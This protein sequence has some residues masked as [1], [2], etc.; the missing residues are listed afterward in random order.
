M[1]IK[2]LP[3]E[4]EDFKDNSRLAEVKAGVRTIELDNTKVSFSEQEK[5]GEKETAYSQDHKEVG[6]PIVDTVYSTESREIGKQKGDNQ[7]IQE[8]G[9]ECGGFSSRNKKTVLI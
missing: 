6:K 9:D 7:L 2:K 8:T 1:R 3:K 5:E 4:V